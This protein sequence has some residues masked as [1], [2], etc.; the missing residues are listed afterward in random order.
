LLWLLLL[1]PTEGVSVEQ[2]KARGQGK[3]N[4]KSIPTCQKEP[5]GNVIHKSERTGPRM[6]LASSPGT[7]NHTLKG[8]AHEDVLSE[9]GVFD[10]LSFYVPL[11]TL[12]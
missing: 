5:G 12:S 3:A 2:P 4:K 11:L 1:G 8:I 10:V 7:Y 6:V 9:D